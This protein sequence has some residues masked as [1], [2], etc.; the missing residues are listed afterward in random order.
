[1]LFAERGSGFEHLLKISVVAMC[2]LL[3]TTHF[4]LQLKLKVV[5]IMVVEHHV[6]E[7][8]SRS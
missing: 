7:S 8:E 4:A 5:T 6:N 1:L 3:H 2:F